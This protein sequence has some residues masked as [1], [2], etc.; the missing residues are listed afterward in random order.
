MDFA[1]IFKEELSSYIDFKKSQGYKEASF[2]GLAR[3]LDIFLMQKNDKTFTDVDCELWRMKT[4]SESNKSHY[5]RVCFSKKFFTYLRLKGYEVSIPKLVAF[6]PSDFQAHIYSREEIVKYFIAVDS[7]SQNLSVRK[8]LQIPIIFRLLYSTGMRIGE[9]L[10]IRKKDYDRDTGSIF[11]PVSK[12]QKERIIFLSASMANLL[13]KFANKTFDRLSDSDFIFQDSTCRKLTNSAIRHHH[14]KFLNMANIPYLGE[15]KG[16][17]IHDFRHTFAVYSF[18]QLLEM[19]IKV[20]VALSIL[21]KY[22]G[23][24][25]IEATEGYIQ[26][27]KSM[28]PDI[29]VPFEEKTMFIFKDL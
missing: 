17:R 7:F 2:S 20:N 19:G 3:K 16:P 15:F 25:S 12:N 5:S 6:I 8:R 23:H 9:V 21:S 28:F 1:S 11:I 18:R 24:S 4:K 13:E 26:I 27:V 14:L 29:L 22:M 10:G